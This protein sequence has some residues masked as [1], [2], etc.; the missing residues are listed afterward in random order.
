MFGMFFQQLDC[1]D[2]RGLFDLT[3]LP[4]LS[5]TDRWMGVSPYL[6]P[7]PMPPDMTP[8]SQR[9]I[10]PRTSGQSLL[11]REKTA[12]GRTQNHQVFSSIADSKRQTDNQTNTDWQ[13]RE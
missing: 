12:N 4:N 2:M 5:S 3:T 1:S 7:L 13:C 11:T 6:W 10:R 8:L 9:M